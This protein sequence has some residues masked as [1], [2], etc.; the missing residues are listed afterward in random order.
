M[1][2]GRMQWRQLSGNGEA[3]GWASR[4]G[5]SEGSGIGAELKRYV[6]SAWRSSMRGSRMVRGIL[7]IGEAMAKRRG[8]SGRTV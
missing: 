6:M 5:T 4:S 8:E 7:D 3:E 2:A 1:T